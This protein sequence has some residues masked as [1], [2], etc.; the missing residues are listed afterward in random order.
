MEEVL[1]ILRNFEHENQASTSLGCVL[2]TQP[3]PMKPQISFFNK[4]DGT[5][6]NFETLSTKCIWSFDSIFIGIQLIQLKLDSL[7]LVV[8]H[9]PYLVHNFVGA[10]M[11]FVQRL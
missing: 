5:C 9:N 8:K 7:A 6:S 10:S 4:C 2:A 1:V 3:Q 11:T